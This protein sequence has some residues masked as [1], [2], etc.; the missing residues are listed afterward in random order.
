[1]RHLTQG[2]PQI[3]SYFGQIDGVRW[4]DIRFGSTIRRFYYDRLSGAVRLYILR[5]ECSRQDLRD[6]MREDRNDRR[7]QSA[8]A[9]LR[10]QP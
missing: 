1:M 10:G 4:G 3:L 2:R 6:G 5:D 9:L 8:E 7:V